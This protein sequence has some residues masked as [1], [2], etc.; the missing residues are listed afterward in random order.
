MKMLFLFGLSSLVRGSIC[1]CVDGSF[2]PVL[3]LSVCWVFRALSSA[4]PAIILG[5]M[6]CHIAHTHTAFVTLIMLFEHVCTLVCVCVIE[7]VLGN[8]LLNGLCECIILSVHDIVHEHINTR[9]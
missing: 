1:L 6:V 8:Q 4:V 3:D 5:L 7:C 2:P 9:P